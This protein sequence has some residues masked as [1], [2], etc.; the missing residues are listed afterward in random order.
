MKTAN[1]NLCAQPAVEIMDFLVFS[2]FQV[3]DE[4]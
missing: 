1:Q 2:G 4:E 3:A